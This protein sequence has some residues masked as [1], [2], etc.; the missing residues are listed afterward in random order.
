MTLYFEILDSK[1]CL[2]YIEFFI[3]FEVLKV[4]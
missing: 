2:K 1:D 4:Q 3:K